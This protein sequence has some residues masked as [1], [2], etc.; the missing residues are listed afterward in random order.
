MDKEEFKDIHNH[1]IPVLNPK[2][3]ARIASVQASYY[4]EIN[5]EKSEFSQ[6]LKKVCSIYDSKLNMSEWMDIKEDFEYKMNYR[7]CKTIFN[8]SIEN[9]D[10]IS[11]IISEYVKSVSDM[12]VILIS[13][14]RSA[15]AEM[16]SFPDTPRKVIV[17]EYTSISAEMCSCVQDVNFINSVLDKIYKSFD[18]KNLNSDEK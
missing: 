4:F 7:L 9:Y 1:Q 13:I 8:F 3:L 16:M 11:E 12:Q 17:S 6:I 14:L 5:G 18:K 15:V 2:S 10:R